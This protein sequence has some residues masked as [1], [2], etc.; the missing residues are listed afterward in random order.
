M[1]QLIFAFKIE[2]NDDHDN[3][4]YPKSFSEVAGINKQLK[5]SAFQVTFDACQHIDWYA[6]GLSKQL[7]GSPIK[8]I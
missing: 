5:R 6:K 3:R 7:Q 8:I 2:Q 4:F 1:R